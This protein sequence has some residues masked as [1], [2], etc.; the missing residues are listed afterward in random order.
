M[1]ILIM[2]NMVDTKK[3]TETECIEVCQKF[4]E[5]DITEAI[6]AFYATYP[7]VRNI[8]LLTY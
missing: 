7:E 8:H 5:F 6:K 3:R 4:I 2:E 1:K